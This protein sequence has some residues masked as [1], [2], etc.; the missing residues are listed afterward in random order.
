VR[1][2]WGSLARCS[3]GEKCERSTCACVWEIQEQKQYWCVHIAARMLVSAQHH[4]APIGRHRMN[5]QLMDVVPLPQG[6]AA[7]S[8]AH[9]LAFDGRLRLKWVTNLASH[10]SDVRMHTF[11]CTHHIVSDVCCLVVASPELGLRLGAHT[12][13][14]C[15]CDTLTVRCWETVRVFTHLCL[16]NSHSGKVFTETRSG[17]GSYRRAIPFSGLSFTLTL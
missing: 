17:I 16:C 13:S 11:L 1:K 6:R 8:H 14:E 3:R 4:Q 9:A 2:R 5:R 15:T 12:R 7:I 10:V